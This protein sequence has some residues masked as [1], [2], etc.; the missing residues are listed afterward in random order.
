MLIVLRKFCS[1]NIFL[2]YT[3]RENIFL[4]YILVLF[5]LL[6]HFICFLPFILDAFFFKNS[7]I[8]IVL[9][10]I[11]SFVFFYQKIPLTPKFYLS[12]IFTINYAVLLPIGGLEF[13]LILDAG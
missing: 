2:K 9:N 6:S 3:F 5:L 13:S 12:S 8:E 4:F 7:S 10:F 1:A 11:I